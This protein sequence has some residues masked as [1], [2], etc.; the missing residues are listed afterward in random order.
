MP[1]HTLASLCVPGYPPTQV[2]IIAPQGIQGSHRSIRPYVY[3]PNMYQ[4]PQ[5]ASEYPTKGKRIAPYGS[6]PE[7]LMQYQHMGVRPNTDSAYQ[8]RDPRMYRQM[9]T[10]QA[11]GQTLEYTGKGFLT[12]TKGR[13]GPA[14]SAK[15]LTGLGAKG[16][17]VG[18]ALN[19]HPAA[20]PYPVQ[21]AHTVSKGRL[22]LSG[23][24]SH[25]PMGIEGAETEADQ[26]RQCCRLPFGQVQGMT[27]PSMQGES[28][29]GMP[30]PK[31]REA[32]P[33]PAM[34]CCCQCRG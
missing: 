16:A 15:G 13:S 18:M 19:A 11:E 20:S 21:T 30:Y 5:F 17:A 14:L 34:L 28:C 3:G 29:T 32:Q 10:G 26:G 8:P 7:N 23:G 25:V 6:S 31:A 9:T 12:G 33:Q 27:P 2:A 1:T 22:Q 24:P 4:A